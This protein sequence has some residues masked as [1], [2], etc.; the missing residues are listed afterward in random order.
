MLLVVPKFKSIFESLGAKLPLPTKILLYSEYIVNHFGVFIVA[1]ILGIVISLKQ[2]YKSNANFKNIFD[3][4][5]LKFYLIGNIIFLSTMSRFF[6]VLTELIKAGIPI[7]EALKIA[8]KT[9][10]NSFIKKRFSKVMTSITKGISFCESLK[11]INL[12]ES[13]LIQMV[14]AGEAS[15]TL[16]D[17]LEKVTNYYNFKFDETIDSISSY[18]EPILLVFIASMVLLMALG[19]F[20]PMW[21]MASAVKT[22][23]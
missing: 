21:D 14:G 22:S 19:I 20:M 2:L 12:V 8:I 4:Y 7:S 11:Q 5:I 13:M 17:M 1:I 9:V 23:Y 10:E 15:G 16:D 18:I 3:R 6:L